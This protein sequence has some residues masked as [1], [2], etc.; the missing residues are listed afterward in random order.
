M[1]VQTI[2]YIQANWHRDDQS[3]AAVK[4]RQNV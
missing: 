4:Q 2:D 1:D 3:S